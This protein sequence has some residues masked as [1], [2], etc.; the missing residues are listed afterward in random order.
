M[1][2]AGQ[3]VDEALPC[4]GLGPGE[5]LDRVLRAVAS[6]GSYRTVQ[7]APDRVQF[8]R[9]F[10]PTWAIV[11]GV[12]TIWIA[13]LGV[14]F[15]FVSTTETCVATVES[16]HTGTRI[17]LHGRLTATTIGMIRAALRG[18][19]PAGASSSVAGVGEPVWATAL[20]A[21]IAVVDLTSQPNIPSPPTAP[22]AAPLLG[23]AAPPVPPLPAALVASPSFPAAAAPPAR[24]FASAHHLTPPAPPLPLPA[25]APV[26]AADAMANDGHG[27][28]TIVVS[29][30][31][32]AVSIRLDDGRVLALTDALQLGRDPD[33]PDAVAVDDPGRSVSKT[34][35]AVTLREGRVGVTDLHSTNGVQLDLGDGSPVALTAGVEM[36]VGDGAVVRFGDRSFVVSIPSAGRSL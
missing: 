21:P 9:T 11:A 31:L 6:D 33:G 12:A 8:A 14:L 18:D 10:R 35:V 25:P 28:R 27:D 34:H 26:R 22:L 29:R 20:D 32:A 7:V 16:D 1:A 24:Q 2:V 13:L 5:A 30:A 3:V 19:Q 4:V 36:L 15:F 17:R 23:A